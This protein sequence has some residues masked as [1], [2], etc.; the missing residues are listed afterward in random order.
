[1]VNPTDKG[2]TAIEEWRKF[3]VEYVTESDEILRKANEL[4][5]IGIK[6]KDAL[7]VAS[8]IAGNAEYF[9]TTDDRLLKKLASESNIIGINPVDLVAIIDERIN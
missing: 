6:P 8:A 9:M 7:H 5:K 3:S 4:V 1:M 2:T